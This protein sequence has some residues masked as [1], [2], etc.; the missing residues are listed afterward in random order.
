M[1]NVEPIVCRV[2]GKVLSSWLVGVSDVAGYLEECFGV[3]A[4]DAGILGD[5]LTV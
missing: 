3:G 2:D 1:R 5:R 4:T